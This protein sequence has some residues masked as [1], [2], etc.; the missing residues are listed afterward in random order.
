MSTPQGIL[1]GQSWI[2]PPYFD[3]QHYSWWKNRME[4]YIYVDDY[5]LWMIIKNGP[6]IPKKAT[7]DG[8]IVPKEP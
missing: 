6:L 5:E 1:E 4:N 8:K 3:G 7:E 2:R